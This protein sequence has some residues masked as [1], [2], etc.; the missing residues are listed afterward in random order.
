MK[1]KTNI[2]LCLLFLVLFF[3]INLKAQTYELPDTNFRNGLNSRYPSVM[4]NNL[5]VISEAGKITGEL[6][7]IALNL[8]DVSGLQY[9]TKINSFNITFNNIKTLPD[10][11]NLKDLQYIFAAYNQLTS[12][13][14]LKS[15]TKLIELHVNNNKLDKLPEFSS[16]KS[17]N[18]LYCYD[19]RLKML[20]DLNNL[21]NLIYLVAGN[22]PLETN[23]DY[24]ILPNLKELHLHNTGIDTVIGLEKLKSLKELYLWGNQIRSLKNIDSL[25]NLELISV[26]NNEL[27]ELPYLTNKPK[28]THLHVGDNK[29]S[30]ENLQV[31]KGNN[32]SYFRYAPQK[33]F[34]SPSYS[35]RSKT[36]LTMSTIIDS[37]LSNNTYVWR[38]EASI[39]DSSSN[40]N[41]TL[42]NVDSSH[43]GN[44]SI[45]IY[46]ADFPLLALESNTFTVSV[47]KCFEIKS[48][49]YE[50]Y[51]TS[52]SKGYDIDLSKL[53]IE[54]GKTPFQYKLSGTNFNTIS[55]NPIFIN[56]PSGKFT[57][58]INDSQ[59][60]SDQFTFT[61]KPI[62]DC[63]EIF[64]P[65]ND[66]V[67]DTYYIEE[68]GEI[69]IYDT[70]RNL[71]KTSYGPFTWDGT[72]NNGSMAE[73]GIYAI[74]IKNKKVK[75]VSIIR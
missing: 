13:G 75:Y 65:N 11:S 22:N 18:N 64:T 66:G 44:Y 25:K 48:Q 24:G 47:Q 35:P 46:N 52:C 58:S 17:L 15:F 51:N 33:K 50:A 73:T 71:I 27:T 36:D 55:Y 61:L 20:P 29:L 8:S 28:L 63:E 40:K 10:L 16:S 70:Q 67:S 12:I 3:G 56:V 37:S 45:K 23:Y 1:K 38:K 62:K 6:N 7:L 49:N 26:F 53:Q 60:C 34:N 74:I 68:S 2:S 39:L 30:F 19:N 14:E 57:L 4:K 9:F 72:T 21:T 41:F 42:L 54:G 31:L 69:N 59:Q 5:L 32:F 43:S